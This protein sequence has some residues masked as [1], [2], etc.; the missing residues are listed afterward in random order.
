ML[1]DFVSVLKSY[2]L[3]SIVLF[4]LI[5]CHQFNESSPVVDSTASSSISGTFRG[6][7]ARS[8][9]PYTSGMCF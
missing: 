2:L 6:R 3:Q 5:E 7:T 9:F 8:C 1:E 4:L